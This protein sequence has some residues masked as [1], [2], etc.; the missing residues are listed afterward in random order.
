[1]RRCWGAK[2]WPESVAPE[3]SWIQNTFTKVLPAPF[4]SWL[5]GSGQGMRCQK[6]FILKCFASV[7]ILCLRKG[8]SALGRAASCS[9]V[10]VRMSLTSSW[11]VRPSSHWKASTRHPPGAGLT[12]RTSSRSTS[13]YAWAN[14]MVSKLHGS[15]AFTVRSLLRRLR[16]S[17][18]A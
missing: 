5:L 1:M 3:A 14:L 18:R 11:G 13:R 10:P 17:G 4:H 12:S 7:H 6:W 9:I 8:S 16:A 15:R 2:C